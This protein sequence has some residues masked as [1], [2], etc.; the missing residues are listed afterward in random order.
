MNFQNSLLKRSKTAQ[1][2]PLHI[3]KIQRGIYLKNT[4]IRFMWTLAFS[5][6]ATFKE[7]VINMITLDWLLR[8]LQEPSA[9]R[10]LEPCA[11]RRSMVRQ[12]VSHCLLCIVSHADKHVYISAKMP[13][14]R[15]SRQPLTTHL[16]LGQL[17][18]VL[19]TR[20]RCKLRI[21]KTSCQESV[22]SLTK[23]MKSI[24]A[25]TSMIS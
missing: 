4:V 23:T 2:M 6:C 3:F 18:W 1:K 19:K 24:S 20:Y 9:S 22:M 21:S 5:I 25:P 7:K 11:I 17:I 13:L 10:W 8:E 16:A 14:N 12:L 15:L